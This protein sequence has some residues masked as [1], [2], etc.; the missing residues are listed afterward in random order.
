VT[1]GPLERLAVD[2]LECA[3]PTW[4]G[5][6]PALPLTDVLAQ[7]RAHGEPVPARADVVGSRLVVDVGGRVRGVAPGQTVVLYDGDRVIGSSTIDSA[8]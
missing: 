6:T 2:R 5:A 1:V 7:V 4:C 8:A 3:A